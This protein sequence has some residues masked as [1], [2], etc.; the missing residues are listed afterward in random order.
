MFD[1]ANIRVLE[2][3][4]RFADRNK[5]NAINGDYLIEILENIRLFTRFAAVKV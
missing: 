5:V 3:H 2:L 1:Q 4:L